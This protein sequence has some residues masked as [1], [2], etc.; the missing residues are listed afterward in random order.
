M[1]KTKKE[2]YE[3]NKRLKKERKMYREFWEVDLLEKRTRQ[4]SFIMGGMW[5]LAILL[6]CVSCFLIGIMF[7]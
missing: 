7:S 4:L 1:N 5:I 2:L 3:E 6:L